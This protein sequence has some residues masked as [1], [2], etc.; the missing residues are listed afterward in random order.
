[1]HRPVTGIHDLLDAVEAA[2]KAAEPSKREAL[3]QTIDAYCNNFPDDFYWAIGPQAP[4]F[5]SRLLQT[6]DSACHVDELIKSDYPSEGGVSVELA[7]P[8]LYILGK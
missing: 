5:L 3:A 4:T 2:V 1:M 7:E 8:F 6:L